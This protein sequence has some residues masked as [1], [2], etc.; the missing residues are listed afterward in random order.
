MSYQDRQILDLGSLTIW[1]NLPECSIFL[2]Q[3]SLH[4]IVESLSG[5]RIVTSRGVTLLCCYCNKQYNHNKNERKN[6]KLFK[7]FL[8][9]YP[10]SSSYISACNCMRP[11][12]VAKLP[13][14]ISPGGYYSI[15]TLEF[16]T[17][18]WAQGCKRKFKTFKQYSI[19]HSAKSL[20]ESWIRTLNH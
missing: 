8:E 16:R 10:P 18:A 4:P 12:C 15:L 17:W 13:T 19:S 5:L 11:K 3:K 7:I 2:L 14:L 1:H 6:L 9:F 20:E